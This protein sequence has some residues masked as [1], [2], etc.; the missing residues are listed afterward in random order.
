MFSLSWA[1]FEQ[2]LLPGFAFLLALVLDREL[3]R[4][5]WALR[6]YAIAA[7]GL[8]LI[9]T[10]TFRKLTWPYVW[11]NWVDGPVKEMTVD[12]GYP[13]MRG[14]RVTPASAEFLTR[15]TNIIDTHSRPDETILCYPNYAMF[16][17]LAHRQP[18]TFAYMHWFD[19]VSD[20]LAREEAERVKQHPPALILLVDFPEAFVRSKEISFRGG[21]RSGQRDLAAAIQSVPG[22]RVIES[23]PIP[24]MDY[25]LKIY[26]K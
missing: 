1:A 9:L 16:Y 21:R 4:R 23:V 24:Y 10:A 12:A 14:L 19:I 2:M 15:V 11:E 7:M 20:N 22:Y 26:G 18:G 25:T 6:G 8:V 3:R 5:G 17:V 13:E